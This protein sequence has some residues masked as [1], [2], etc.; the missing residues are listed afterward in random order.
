MKTIKFFLLFNLFLYSGILFTICIS[1]LAVYQI[2]FN[3][4]KMLI[5]NYHQIL[6]FILLV[7]NFILISIKTVKSLLVFS[8]LYIAKLIESRKKRSDFISVER[9]SFSN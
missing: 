5:I 8:N 2:D 6:P 7:I 4:F 9:I 1:A 3:S